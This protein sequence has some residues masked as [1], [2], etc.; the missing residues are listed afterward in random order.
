MIDLLVYAHA[1]GRTYVMLDAEGRCWR[2]PAEQGG[3]RQRQS[4]SQNEVDPD[5]QY[6]PWQAL[7][8]LRLSGAA[9]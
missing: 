2:W 6:E 4:C 9:R 3:W 8:A 7:L 1:D 5:R